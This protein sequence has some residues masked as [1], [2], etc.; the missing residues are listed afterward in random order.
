MEMETE[1][2][3]ATR[4]G[5][6]ILVLN[7]ISSSSSIVKMETETKMEMKTKTDQNGAKQHSKQL[8]RAKQRANQQHY[9]YVHH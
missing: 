6:V 2:A 1:I 9:S 3:K 8:K 4:C 5:T 7:Q